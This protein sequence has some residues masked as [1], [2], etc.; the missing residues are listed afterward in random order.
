MKLPKGIILHVHAIHK[1]GSLVGIVQSWNQLHEGGLGTAGTTDNANAFPGGHVKINVL[2]CFSC[3][4]IIIEGHVAEADSGGTGHILHQCLSAVLHAGLRIENLVDPSSGSSSLGKHNHQVR[5]HHQGQQDLI[6]VVDKSNH[7]ALGHAAGIDTNAAKPKDNNNTKVQNQKTEGRKD[8]VQLADVDGVPCKVIAGLIEPFLLCVLLAE[9]TN[10]T[11]T[12]KVLPGNQAYTVRLLLNGLEERH[13]LA[14]DQIQHQCHQR[15]DG[16][17]HQ[18]QGQV[19]AHGHDH[20]TNYQERR[21]NHQTNQ[22]GHSGLHLVNVRGHTGD[23]GRRTE[24]I[25]FL[26]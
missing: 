13:G 18:R 26:P 20:C 11:S 10:H 22:H 1:D 8:S 19:N 2:Q 14:H 12:G 5:H 16:Q 17:E 4:L 6:H 9:G 3:T 23:Q 7:F 15:N 25:Q 21:T 24:A